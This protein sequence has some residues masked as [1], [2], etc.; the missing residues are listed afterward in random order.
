MAHLDLVME[1]NLVH[2]NILERWESKKYFGYALLSQSREYAQMFA[3]ILTITLPIGQQ[4]ISLLS[5]SGVEKLDN[6]LNKV[7]MR[8]LECLNQVFRYIFEKVPNS[9]K[10]VS[11]FLEKALEFCPFLVHNVLLA[12]QRPDIE[13][14]LQEHEV[15]S[16]ALVEAIETLVLFA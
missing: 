1:W 4:G 15:F 5:F 12:A 2:V 7:K 6:L 11:P 3:R 8:G 9:V 13:H 14:V 10:V 16:E